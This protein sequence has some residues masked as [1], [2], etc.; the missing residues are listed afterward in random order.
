[1]THPGARCDMGLGLGL[2]CRG[3]AG[4]DTWPGL[5]MAHHVPGRTLFQLGHMAR[6]GASAHAR[7]RWWQ[8]ATTNN[9]QGKPQ[10][11]F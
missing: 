9:K 5:P 1:M 8:H 11:N 10:R 2:L 6:A 4:W 3:W 7:Q